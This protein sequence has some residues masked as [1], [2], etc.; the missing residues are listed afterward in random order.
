MHKNPYQS[1]QTHLKKGNR[2]LLPQSFDNQRELKTL[3][4]IIKGFNK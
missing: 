3:E 1:L 2:L 4:N